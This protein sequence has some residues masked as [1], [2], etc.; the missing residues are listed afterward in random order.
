M[1]LT[2]KK[3]EEAHTMLK[4]LASSANADLEA[5]REEAHE[6]FSNSTAGMCRFVVGF[7]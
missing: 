6:Y 3:T 1:A 5:A 7:I 2:L 4:D